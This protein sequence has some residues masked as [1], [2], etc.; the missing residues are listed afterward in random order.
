MNK[1]LYNEELQTEFNKEILFENNGEMA[2]VEIKRLLEQA[3]KD[4]AVSSMYG[5][6]EIDDPFRNW[7]EKNKI[8]SKLISIVGSYL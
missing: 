5:S 4:G 3:F 2:V 6:S 8:Q 1:T 7:F